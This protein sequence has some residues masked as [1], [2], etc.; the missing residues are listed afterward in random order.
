MNVSAEGTASRHVVAQPK[1]R[2]D[3]DL[4]KTVFVSSTYQDLVAYRSAVWNVLS[5]FNVTVRGMEDFG[6]RPAGPLAT[7]LAELEQSDVC[8]LIVGLRLGSIETETGLP[9]TQVEYRHAI[10]TGKPVL[11]YLIDEDNASVVPKDI[12][13]ESEAIEKLR[14]FKKTLREKH[15][16]SMFKSVEDLT[17]K[18]RH[19]FR[20]QFQARVEVSA[21]T[22][23]VA[24]LNV[25]GVHLR[26]F[27]L[28]PK[29]ISGREMRL[30]VKLSGDPF[31]LSR[32]LCDAFRM[33][34][35]AAVGIMAEVVEPQIGAFRSIPLCATG[36]TVDAFLALTRTPAEHDI[37]ARVQFSPDDVSSVRAELFGHY[38]QMFDGY[39]DQDTTWIPAEG[40]VILQFSKVAV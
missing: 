6:A 1:E 3:V 11:V 32:K 29:A 13:F 28:T 24:E 26:R 10:T 23:A 5:E 37:Y 9:F 39:D 38:V 17:E 22:A 14:A 8:V 7:C 20:S 31:Q 18:V 16:V 27:L 21:S 34:Y 2:R 30:R 12:D 36:T 40:R 19:D 15:T 33:D 35:G 4:P 25:A